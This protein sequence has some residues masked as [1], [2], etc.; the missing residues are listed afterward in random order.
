[1]LSF[2]SRPFALIYGL[3]DE[4][5]GVCAYALLPPGETEFLGGGGLDGDVVRTDAHD[6]RHTLLH[7]R[8]VRVEFGLLGADS[9]IDVP[10]PVAFRGNERDHLLQDD[11]AIHVECVIGVVGEMIT[12]VAHIGGTEKGIADGMD[13]H[14]GIAMTQQSQSMLYLNASEP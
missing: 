4:H 7:G 12:D 14:I 10:H 11:F 1:M 3:L 8:D 6:L 13:E 5:D 2:K 9:G